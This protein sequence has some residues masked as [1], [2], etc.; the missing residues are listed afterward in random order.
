MT[1]RR[2]SRP[3]SPTEEEVGVRPAIWTVDVARTAGKASSYPD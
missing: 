2:T 3:R 1:R